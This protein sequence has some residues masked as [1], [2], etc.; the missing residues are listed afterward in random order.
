[1]T[2]FRFSVKKTDTLRNQVFKDIKR[3]II[4]GKIKPGTRLR[5]IDLSKEMGLSRGPIREAILLLERD[6]LLVTQTHR[7]TVVADV[8]D[9]EVTALLNPLRIL[10]ETYAL[11]KIYLQLTDED[12]M[13]LEAILSELEAGCEKNQLETVIEKDLQFH[14][15]LIHA[16][17]EPYLMAIWSGVSSRIIFHFMTNGRKHQEDNFIKLIEEHRSLLEAI[18]SRSWSDIEAELQRHIY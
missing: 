2:D 3:A 6:G 17:K 14:E 5:E 1:M 16:T 4:Y 12:Y 11:K 9:E 13:R 8:E 7:E 15:Y 18:Q 10:L